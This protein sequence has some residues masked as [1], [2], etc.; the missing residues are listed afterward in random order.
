M[1]FNSACALKDSSTHL[2]YTDRGFSISVL[3]ILDYVNNSAILIHK[4]RISP[5]EIDR[6]QSPV[7]Q[8]EAVFSFPFPGYEAFPA[9]SKIVSH[10]D[11][12]GLG[13]G[14]VN[15]GSCRLHV[16]IIRQNHK[17]I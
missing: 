12:A 2:L 1:R 5:H 7:S 15:Y 10:C 9:K 4:P 6:F 11:W 14:K 3:F 17:G 8:Q 13:G 16:H